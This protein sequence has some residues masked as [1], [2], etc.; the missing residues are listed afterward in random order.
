MPLEQ[1]EPTDLEQAAVTFERLKCGDWMAHG[2]DISFGAPGIAVKACA[3]L[4]TECKKMA[5][6]NA[7][8]EGRIAVLESKVMGLT[9]IV[10][11]IDARLPATQPAK[12]E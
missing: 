11:S 2:W 4:I 12:D 10:G 3:M 7:D 8:L 5:E 9:D 6:K 1:A